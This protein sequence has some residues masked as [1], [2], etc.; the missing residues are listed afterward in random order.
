MDCCEMCADV[1]DRRPA[2]VCCISR[3]IYSNIES[4]FFRIL[5]TDV[6]VLQCLDSYL[7][8]SSL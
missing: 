4:Q 3:T 2:C 1:N 8:I 5:K 6:C 7:D